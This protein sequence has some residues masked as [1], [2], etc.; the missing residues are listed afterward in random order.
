MK[1]GLNKEGDTPLE[2]RCAIAFSEVMG[3]IALCGLERAIASFSDFS[4]VL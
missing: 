3:A 4:L 2:W 1:T